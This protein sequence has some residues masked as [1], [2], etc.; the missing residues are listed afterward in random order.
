MKRMLAA[1]DAPR[2]SIKSA[3]FFARMNWG[4]CTIPSSRWS[5]GMR[6]ATRSTMACSASAI[7]AQL[8]GRGPARRISYAESFR[9]YVGLDPHTTPTS[10]LIAAARA[11]GHSPPP[12]SLAA[13]DRDG[14]LDWL[15]VDRVQPHLGVAEPALL[16]DDPATQAAL[17]RVRPG[18]PAVAERF[19]LYVSGIE[20]ANGYLELLDAGE[21]RRRNAEVNV[22]R[23]ADGKAALPEQS[24]LLAA[25]ESGLPASVGVA[26]GFDRLVMLAAGAAAISEVI[27][28]PFDRA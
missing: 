9:Q 19:E 24:R 16:Y 6:S 14:W 17:A 11:A 8:L 7:C 4:R 2:R 3:A 10:E 20:L 18:D 23:Q 12:E 22:Q 25:M 5:S 28:F 27:A 21:L 1:G 26:L 13:A 15:L